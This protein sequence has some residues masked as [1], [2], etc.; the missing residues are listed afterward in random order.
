MGGRISKRNEQ[1][2]AVL[3]HWNKFS[4]APWHLPIDCRSPVAAQHPNI[5]CNCAAH[6]TVAVAKHNAVCRSEFVFVTIH[7][8]RQVHAP[9]FWRTLRFLM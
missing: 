2:T 7:A 3:M 8:V 9:F 6:I 5:V 1:L 4:A